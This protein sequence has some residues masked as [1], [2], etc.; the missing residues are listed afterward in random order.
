M[1]MPRPRPE[2]G[3]ETRKFY[4]QIKRDF[5]VEP[6]MVH[7]LLGTCE[8]LNR[9]YECREILLAE[10]LTFKTS[11]GQVKAHPLLVEQKNTWAGFLAGIKLLGLDLPDDVK[12]RPAHRPPKGPGV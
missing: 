9:F 1:A 10:G 3:K 8:R 7:A 12:K 6:E 2:W 5:D 11:T 4:A